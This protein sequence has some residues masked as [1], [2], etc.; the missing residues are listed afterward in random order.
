MS[1]LSS[2]C[3]HVLDKQG[4]I[5]KL[6][7]ESNIWTN[8]YIANIDIHAHMETGNT[9]YVIA[10]Y[11]LRTCRNL[12]LCYAINCKNGRYNDTALF[13]FRLPRYEDRTVLALEAKT[14]L[15]IVSSRS[16]KAICQRTISIKFCTF[17]PFLGFG[18]SIR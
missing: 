1:S 3:F 7:F 4:A 8:W 9:P 16:N 5:T 18:I 14:K 12:P 6:W 10:H 17:S 15:C 13:L 2:S 11:A